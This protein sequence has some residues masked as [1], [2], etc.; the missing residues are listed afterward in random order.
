MPIGRQESRLGP[1]P[2][3]HRERTIMGEQTKEPADAGGEDAL[4]QV[5]RDKAARIRERGGNPFSNRVAE[6]ERSM[7]AEL[8]QRFAEALLEPA[9]ELRYDPEKVAALAGTDPV[10]LCGRIM[11]RRG[12]GKASFLPLRD[13]SGELQLFAKADVMGD[14]FSALEDLD[15]ADHVQAIGTPMVTQKGEL[16]LMLSSLELLSKALRPLPDKWAGLSDVDLRYRRRYVDMV[17][18]PEV[19]SVLA[20]R[21]SVL[22]G[23]RSFLDG[24]GFIEVETPSLHSVIGGAAAKPFKTHHNALDLELFLRIAPELYLKR[25]LVGGFERVYEIGRAYRNEGISTRHNPEFTIVE[26]YQAYATYDT[27]MTTTEALLAHVDRRLASDMQ[28]RGLGA[29]YAAWHEARGFTLEE[30]FARVPMTQ[31]IATASAHAGLPG[32][33]HELLA[34]LAV[35]EA[36]PA[37]RRTRADSWVKEWAAGSKRVKRI[38]W[39]NFR[40]GLGVCESQGERIFA[41]YEYLAEPFLAEDYR[42]QDGSRSLPVFILDYPAEVSPLA[43]RKDSD[44]SLVDRFELFVEG[45]ELCNAFSELN[46]PDDQAARFKEQVEKKSRGHDET[47]DFDE[48]YV[49]ALQHGMPPAAGFGLGVDRLLM[50][51]TQQ[52]SIRDVIAFPLLRP[53]SSQA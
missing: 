12:F 25:L 49:R 35:T 26:F 52:P 28:T 23:L 45:R 11:A 14:A 48:D 43:R 17:A 32:N 46:D 41:A 18:N 34:D 6:S 19:Q 8:R 47:M 33:M 4:I 31:A 50:A 38:E 37:D 36:T 24:Q 16:S 15:I 1:A 3:L 44:P 42:S 29:T 7:V 30:P 39:T 2:A 21:A 5:R 13:G 9:H 10:T 27:L 22:A 51:L 20:A 53:E 40:K